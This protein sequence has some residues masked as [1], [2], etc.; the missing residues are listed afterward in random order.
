M[1]RHFW[2]SLKRQGRRWLRLPWL[3][4]VLL[5][6]SA[7]ILLGALISLGSLV[8][9][10]LG[11]WLLGTPQGGQ[12]LLNQVPGVQVHGFEGILLQR[13]QAEE[14]SWQGDGIQLQLE[15]PAVHL[16]LSCLLQQEICIR[17][18]QAGLVQL[19]L[20]EADESAEPFDWQT[21]RMPE[22]TLPEL[23]LPWP[24]SLD[25][26]R[27]GELQVNGQS[28]L[29]DLVLGARWQGERLQVTHLQLHSP[30]LP[31]GIETALHLA[32]WLDFAQPWPLNVSMQT[33][34]D[35]Q[36]L[37]LDLSGSLAQLE[38][39]AQLAVAETRTQLEL[40]GWVQ[41]LQPDL[42][43]D[44]VLQ[45]DQLDPGP[46]SGLLA[47]WPTGLVVDTTRLQLQGN[48]EQGWNLLLNSQLQL[49]QQPLQVDLDAAISWT[50]LQ[51]HALD[52]RQ[53]SDRQLMFRGQ[54]ELQEQR[55]DFLGQLDGQL[56]LPAGLTRASLD[57]NGFWD[58]QQ[59]NTY[60]LVINHLGLS[61][62]DQHLALQANLDPQTWQA[63]LQLGLTELARLPWIQDQDMAGDVQ[64]QLALHL[65]A[66]LQ[67][68]GQLPQPHQWL[69]LLQQA[70][71]DL[72]LNSASFSHPMLALQG[73]HLNLKVDGREAQQDPVLAL[74]LQ[75]AEVRQ[76]GELLVSQLAWTLAG[77]LS[78]QHWD[79]QL[80]YDRQPLQL[81]LE[82][83]I[84]TL[85]AETLG[86]DYRLLDFELNQL[87]AW[88]PED[89]RWQSGLSGRLQ[90]QW[91]GASLQAELELVSPAGAIELQ[92]RDVLT[93]ETEWLRL[94]YEQL[95]V[96]LALE[97]DLLSGRVDLDGE[98]LGHLDLAVQ[99]PV[100]AA[101]GEDRALQGEYQIEG[102]QLQLF[103]PF[104]DV[105]ELSGVLQGAG[106]IRGQL[107]QPEVWGNLQFQSVQAAD[108]Q[109]PVT[110]ERLDG[111]L[112][113]QG[114]QAKLQADFTLD[115]DGR[116]RLQGSLAWRP[117]LEAHLHLSGEPF[118]LRVDPWAELKVLPDLYLDYQ[119]GGVRL[120][121]VINVPSGH[122]SINQ[123]PQQAVQVSADARVVGEAASESQPVDLNLD[124]EILI[125]REKLSLD[126]FGLLADLQGRLRVGRDLDT[127]GELLLVN[128]VYQS[129]GQDL[130][131]RRARLIFA[132]PAELPFLDIEAVRVVG[133][134]TAGLR[135]T[136]RADQPETEIFS[137]PAMSNEQA[138]SWLLLGRPLQAEAD[139][140]AM[141]TAAISLGLR[142]TTGFTQRLGDAVGIRE[143]HLETEGSGSE[144]SV[145]AAGYINDRL[146]VRYGVGLYD[147]VTRFAVRYELSKQIYVEAASALASSLDIFWRV[148]Y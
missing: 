34:L 126:A 58:L 100:R 121:G 112:I 5:V 119:Q 96:Q 92:H 145:M 7:V 93:G 89:L 103:R 74:D 111:E 79:L 135:I 105:D 69:D 28:H 97:N 128:G 148:D 140:N 94:T 23:S 91:Q 15:R 77:R 52:L 25:E 118:Q 117:E 125:G 101:P 61:L 133:D 13:W 115:G 73:T 56:Q 41:L 3:L 54:A 20:D 63:A 6:R 2:V 147:E 12:W 45:L 139:E 65:P 64:L 37:T 21:F 98:Q 120:S 129:W 84:T 95:L 81:A 22:I 142:G 80:V 48:L 4:L 83:G 47:Q 62:A 66:L 114:Y 122:I 141:N 72:Q 87:Q 78:Q 18:L 55:L 36:P 30:W 102:L 8:L 116:G 136:G 86:W 113:L 17:Q 131:L 138:L 24:V 46:S 1:I 38:L 59:P 134:V 51:I 109:W 110:L 57:L 32:G 75:L 26:L 67:A 29:Q 10:L 132:G 70:A 16:R 60:A 39:Q 71:L 9:L 99:L 35:G 11:M 19:T 107:L 82:G 108:L 40:A 53:G 88:L 44:L 127:R 106:E 49:E 14:L 33:Q 130:Q 76:Q 144:A 85:G 143:L 31:D 27:L 104:A 42:P 68:D 50:R 90:G 124:L 123:L 146:S 137:E 43:V